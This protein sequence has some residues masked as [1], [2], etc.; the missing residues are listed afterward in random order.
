VERVPE[1]ADD[2]EFF[3][4]DEAVLDGAGYALACFDFIAVI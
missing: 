4:L 1:F 3:T 2:E